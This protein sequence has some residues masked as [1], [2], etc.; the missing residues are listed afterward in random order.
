MPSVLGSTAVR[1]AP[2]ERALALVASPATRG[3]ATPLRAVPG[4][5]SSREGTGDPSAGRSRPTS[6]SLTSAQT[7]KM[8]ADVLARHTQSFEAADAFD[9]LNHALLLSRERGDEVPCLGPGAD[10]W[11]SEDLE[12]QQVA[13]D[14]CLDCPMSVFAV[15]QRYAE[16]AKPM[17]GT[18]AG[19]AH[20]EPWRKPRAQGEQ[21]AS[22]PRPAP[23]PRPAGTGLDCT[24]GCGGTTKGGWYL[25]G[26][27]SLHLAALI[28]R[29]RKRSLT[30]DGALAEVAHSE[31]LTAKLA[32]R[33]GG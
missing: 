32:A 9:D 6:P 15:C 1:P 22:A 17:A 12:E 13:A 23:I 19:V 4:H 33:L 18:W 21:V 14:L 30:V 3:G 16:A 20:D 26:H 27:D 5:T 29:V 11:T 31:R 28:G 24:C 10:A 8:L 25:S 7:D 2:T